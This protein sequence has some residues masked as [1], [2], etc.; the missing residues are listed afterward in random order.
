MAAGSTGAAAPATS[1]FY[2][3]PP[4]GY[5]DHRRVLSSSVVT[6][7]VQCQNQF[8]AYMLVNTFTNLQD[9]STNLGGTY[10]LGRDI[11]ADNMAP[12][13][14]RFEP[15]NGVL[16]GLGHKITDAIIQSRQRQVG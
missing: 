15:F 4:N 1:S 8:T 7:A 10:A 11:N 2:Y 9:I 6:N 5:T 13:G 12:I 3:N 14:S 16:D